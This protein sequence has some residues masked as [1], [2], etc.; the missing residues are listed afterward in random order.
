MNLPKSKFI[1]SHA[2]KE[3]SLLKDTSAVL[4]TEKL[5]H[6]RGPKSEA[7]DSPKIAKNKR[8]MKSEHVST[9]TALGTKKSILKQ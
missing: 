4:K 8:T 9:K 5:S 1:E 7:T 6:V 3:E 2:D